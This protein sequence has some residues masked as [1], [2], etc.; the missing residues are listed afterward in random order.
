MR[1]GLENSKVYRKDLEIVSFVSYFKIFAIESCF[2][3]M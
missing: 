1:V 2:L 3:Y